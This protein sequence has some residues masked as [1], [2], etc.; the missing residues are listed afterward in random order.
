LSPPRRTG[1][2]RYAG[3]CDERMAALEQTVRPLWVEGDPSKQRRPT[4]Y[5]KR[6][7]GP[8][9]ARKRHSPARSRGHSN[10][11][12][13]SN[14]GHSIRAAARHNFSPFAAS[15]LAARRAHINWNGID[16]DKMARTLRRKNY[17]CIAVNE[18]AVQHGSGESTIS[19]ES[20]ACTKSL[21]VLKKVHLLCMSPRQPAKYN[22]RY[23]PAS[24][25]PEPRNA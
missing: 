13:A 5:S 16:S 4:P 1:A 14:C 12:S 25:Q 23:S 18:G 22:W 8:G 3:G 21:V 7:I 15:R 2:P 24:V 19:I 17:C 20:T 6:S 10:V 9:S 11:G